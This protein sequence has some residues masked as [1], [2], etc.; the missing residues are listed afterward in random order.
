MLNIFIFKFIWKPIIIFM[1]LNI[2]G[3]GF[4]DKLYLNNSYIKEFNADIVEFISSDDR[5]LV[6]LDNTAFYP[7]GG[8]QPSD[9]GRIGECTVSYV[10]E[11]NNKIYHV[12]DKEPSIYKNINCTIDW[13]RRFDYMQQHCGQH[14]LSACF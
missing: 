3:A 2:E 10:Y 8:G 11:D 14:I 13:E 9:T 7:D 12:V 5:L 4:M 1:I 6:V